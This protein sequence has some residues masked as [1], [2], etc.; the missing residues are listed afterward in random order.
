MRKIKWLLV[1]LVLGVL[2]FTLS[3]DVNAQCASCCPGGQSEVWCC[4]GGYCDGPQDD[5]GVCLDSNDWVEC[6]DH[7]WGCCSDPPPGDDD[8]DGGCA[9]QT[10]LSGICTGASAG[11]A[12]DC[13]ALGGTWTPT[14]CDY[15]NYA[16]TTYNPACG[17]CSAS[18]NSGQCQYDAGSGD[19]QWTSC[20]IQACPVPPG[21]IL[22]RVANQ[23]KID[24][25]IADNLIENPE[26]DNC[27]TRVNEVADVSIS[28][29]GVST[30]TT[31]PGVCID[32]FPAYSQSLISGTYTVTANVPV[33]W[34]AK[35]WTCTPDDSSDTGACP[36][37]L[38]DGGGVSGVNLTSDKF[39]HIWFYIRPIAPSCS[40]SDI[41]PEVIA[42]DSIPISATVRALGAPQATARLYK[43]ETQTLTGFVGECTASDTCTIS[44]SPWQTTIGDIG[45]TYY[46]FCRGWNDSLR[47]CRPF[48][49][50]VYP[51]LLDCDGTLGDG[52]MDSSCL[53]V[54][55]KTV[56][57]TAPGHWFQTQGG[58]VHVEGTIQSYV[59]STVAASNQ[60]F[61][62]NSNPLDIATTYPG[63]ITYVGLDNY[64]FYSG[65]TL[66]MERSSTKQWL[67][68]SPFNPYILAGKT[69]YASYYQK[70]GSPVDN[71]FG[72]PAENYP[73][74]PYD[75][76]IFYSD[77]D[78]TIAGV[79][80]W[81]IP[82]NKK[83]IV[84]INSD[85]NISL[86][87]GYGITV[88][89]GGFLAFIVKE[90]INIGD[91]V[92]NLQG[93]YIAEG[94]I[95]TAEEGAGKPFTGEGLFYGKTGVILA[96]DLGD[97]CS[98]MCNADTPAEL[99]TF[100]P[101]LVINSPYE[102]W[103]S[104]IDWQEVAP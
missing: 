92:G 89:P 95:E 104:K 39:V 79:N 38:G 9:P 57:I 85:L 76:N 61:N 52:L 19:W 31:T 20:Y 30:A 2:V 96:R 41:P 53:D 42:G 103:T 46:V 13:A 90:N 84:L 26:I 40:V 21:T 83:V 63:L 15:A 72:D 1:L 60:F 12:G 59:P 82:A 33:G 97:D 25:G 49:Y 73:A 68:D 34:E 17:Y 88:E 43:A 67:A 99:F 23:A 29:T 6:P 93:I 64:D 14:C 62:L 94:T 5:D 70:L 80:S 27:E 55:C 35:G 101:D 8:D 86:D 28:F 78:V 37:A 11:N 69:T 48:S 24:V 3:S 36:A 18:C 66:G 87:D 77:I 102:L 47:E 10:C 65:S 16:S 100:N 98:E 4:T 91:Q 71:N 44:P 22:G 74:L 81:N 7:E 45:K 75:T 50:D 58:D 56:K 32:S 54:D 51:R